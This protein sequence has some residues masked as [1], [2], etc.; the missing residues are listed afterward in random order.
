MKELDKLRAELDDL[1]RKEEQIKD[2]FLEKIHKLREES[3]EEIR[4]IRE[5]MAKIEKVC[6]PIM[7]AGPKCDKFI[8]SSELDGELITETT[9]DLW[10]FCPEFDKHFCS[11]SCHEETHHMITQVGEA[12]DHVLEHV[13][14]EHPG[15]RKTMRRDTN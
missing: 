8:L 12:M 1:L 11:L 13:L 14:E 3:R 10:P 15:V 7:C 9:D 2:D 4:L 5:S 6:T